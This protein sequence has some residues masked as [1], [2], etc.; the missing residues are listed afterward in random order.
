MLKNNESHK[1]TYPNKITKHT[2]KVLA[3]TDT[4]THM[5]AHTSIYHIK[6]T[7]NQRWKES[8]KDCSI[9]YVLKDSWY[10]RN[11][12]PD[13]SVDLHVDIKNSCN[14]T[15]KGKYKKYF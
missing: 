7:E 6:T 12:M 10:G 8:S 2:I 14:G 5:H 13:R 4:Y 9:R 11:K 1:I 15:K 3:C